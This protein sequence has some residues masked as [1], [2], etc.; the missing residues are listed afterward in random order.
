[1]TQHL[2][3]RPAAFFLSAHHSRPALRTTT[4]PAGLVLPLRLPSPRTASSVPVGDGCVR[5]QVRARRRD[6]LRLHPRPDPR[7]HRGD[8]AAQRRPRR[9]RRRRP[10]HTLVHLPP[11]R[12]PGI[13][14][15][16]PGGAAHATG[17]P[18]AARWPRLH[19]GVHLARGAVRAARLVHAPRWRRWRRVLAAGMRPEATEVRGWRHVSKEDSH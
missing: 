7:L 13:P 2:R 6:R 12:D 3:A 11:R 18:Q 17:S 14:P 16:S 10:R 5:R 19:R 8:L 1:M 9:G 4:A 15:R